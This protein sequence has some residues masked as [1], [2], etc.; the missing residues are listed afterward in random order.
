MEIRQNKE[1]ENIFNTFDEDGSGMAAPALTYRHPR[2]RGDLRA[3][4]AERHSHLEVGLGRHLQ[5]A[6]PRDLRRRRQ[7]RLREPLPG[8]VRCCREER[9]DGPQVRRDHAQAQGSEQVR[10]VRCVFMGRINRTY[11]RPEAHKA[12]EKIYIPVMFED[13]LQYL[14]N[15]IKRQTILDQISQATNEEPGDPGRRVEK[16]LSKVMEEGFREV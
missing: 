14:S 10:E 15:N 13:M 11:N 1:I 7:R 4:R 2:H 16:E 12:S 6:D 8:G 5:G 9:G 3:L